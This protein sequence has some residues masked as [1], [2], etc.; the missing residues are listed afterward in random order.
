MIGNGWVGN[1]PGATTSS[2]L[3]ASLFIACGRF[4]LWHLSQGPILWSMFHLVATWKDVFAHITGWVW[5]F[6]RDL[7]GIIQARKAY[8]RTKCFHGANSAATSVQHD[9]TGKKLN[10]TCSHWNR[11][12]S[13]RA[14]HGKNS[15]RQCNSS[16]QMPKRPIRSHPVYWIIHPHFLRFGP[17]R[18][19]FA[20]S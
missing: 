13:Q 20:P 8:K 4:L 14:N 6:Q 2:N 1:Y 12:W 15:S 5:T 9:K 17:S 19:L 11:P 18:A 16:H 7:K 3:W 10:G